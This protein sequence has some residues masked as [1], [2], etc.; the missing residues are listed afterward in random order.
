M[1]MAT[2]RG[3][4]VACRG[5]KIGQIV[6]QL[7]GSAQQASLGTAMP[8]FPIDAHDCLDQGLPLGAGHRVCRA[9]DLDSP[10]FISIACNVDRCRGAGGR[11][12]YAR[13]LARLHQLV[14]NVEESYE[15]L[16][17]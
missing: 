8:D 2:D 16:S 11:M 13:C 3:G 6:G 5:G 9:E 7:A 17:L 15:V 14:L 1:P 10:G 12:S 4:G